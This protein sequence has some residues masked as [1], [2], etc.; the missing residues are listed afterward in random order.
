MVH[1]QFVGEI[2]GVMSGEI[3]V[4]ME[5]YER[6]AGGVGGMAGGVGGMTGGVGGMTGGV[7]GMTGGVGGWGEWNPLFQPR[8]VVSK[9]RIET[10]GHF[11]VGPDLL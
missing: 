2:N 8:G 1:K 6:M 3:N 10:L 4:W 9:H 11:D 7:G 5:D